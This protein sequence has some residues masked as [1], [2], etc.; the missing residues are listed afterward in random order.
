M[1]ENLL[2]KRPTSIG[3]SF[4]KNIAVGK[5]FSYFIPKADSKFYQERIVLIKKKEVEKYLRMQ[6][7]E[8]YFFK[9]SCVFL[10]GK[11]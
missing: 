3:Y 9:L 11:E 10:I 6:I 2:E 1:F 4:V 7:D 5:T 8:Q